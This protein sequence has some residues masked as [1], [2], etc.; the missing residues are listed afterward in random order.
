MGLNQRHFQFYNLFQE[1]NAWKLLRADHAWWILAFL[2]D[3]F[4]EKTTVEYTVAQAALS[5][6]LPELRER[7][8]LSDS[9]ATARTYLR[10]WINNGWLRES[11][12]MLTRTDAAMVAIH[13]LNGIERR[14]STA[15]ASHLSV[16]QTMARDLAIALSRDVRERAGLL[17]AQ[18][19]EIAR[20]LSDLKAGQ[21]D[22]LPES[23]HKESVRALYHQCVR[24]LQ[25][26]R[27]VEG[28]VENMDRSIRQK[29]L[30]G[31]GGRGV[32]VMARLEGER[33]LADTDAGQAFNGFFELLTDESRS[34][35]F[36]D[37]LASICQA[38]PDAMLSPS[39]K[40][41]LKRLDIVL[42]A[43]S[44]RVFEKRQAT[45]ENLRRVIQSGVFLEKRRIDHLIG[46][47][48]RMAIALVEGGVPLRINTGM[49]IAAGKPAR[50]H[51]MSIKPR[52]PD[53]DIDT[54]NVYPQVF[55]EG[56][57]DAEVLRHLSSVSATELASG[58]P[59]LLAAHGPLSLFEIAE[60]QPITRGLEELVAYIR[61]A[62]GIKAPVLADRQLIP[63]TDDAGGR[64]LARV[65]KYMLSKELFPKRIGEIGL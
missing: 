29:L 10:N 47:L 22:T 41:L 51:P 46:E 11:E 44:R 20:K 14:E 39:E 23:A 13:F 49:Y 57:I 3:L 43:E 62:Q 26:F 56:D 64:Y 16:A 7:G 4:S 37:Q 38:T 63:F 25:D 36:S 61:I 17:K 12:Q 42:N 19:K 21:V 18:S 50:T 8:E 27:L 58:L 5:E 15:S 53:D 33:A 65:Y 35:E 48:E 30:E 54:R 55:D 9:G 60:H 1:A 31:N 28:D 24:L 52:W 6:L 34:G 2:Q 40:R 59:A 32:A 45:N